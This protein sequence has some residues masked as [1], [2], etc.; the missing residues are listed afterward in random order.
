MAPGELVI[1]KD[2]SSRWAAAVAD[3][4]GTSGDLCC[5]AAFVGDAGSVVA[6]SFPLSLIGG[7]G[8]YSAMYSN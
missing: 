4:E 7:G 8:G 2:L 5:L 3:G 1:A 6:L